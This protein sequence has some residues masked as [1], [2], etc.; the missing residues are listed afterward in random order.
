[1]ASGSIHDS[2]TSQAGN[3][4][5]A[6]TSGNASH[7][8]I[9]RDED[10]EEGDVEHDRSSARHWFRDPTGTLDIAFQFDGARPPGGDRARRCRG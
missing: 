5:G 3:N 7:L 1:M 2:P 6:R 10:R 9:G 4:D 8:T